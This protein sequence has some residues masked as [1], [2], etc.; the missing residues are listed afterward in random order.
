[1]DD[2]AE[3]ATP[4]AKSLMGGVLGTSIGAVVIALIAV[5]SLLLLIRHMKRLSILPWLLPP[6]SH[7]KS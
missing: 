5:V 7:G 3:N 6:P 1:M 4:A 2:L